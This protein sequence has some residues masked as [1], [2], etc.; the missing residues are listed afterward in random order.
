MRA[1]KTLPRQFEFYFPELDNSVL[2]ETCGDYVTIR[3]AR[4]NFPE[5]RKPFFVRELAAEGHIPDFYEAFTDGPM[6]GSEG[7]E[8][9]LD[10]SWLKIAPWW[11]RRAD[12]FM[13]RLLVCSV[14]C[15][16]IMMSR[17]I[18]SDIPVGRVQPTQTTIS[19]RV[20]PGWPF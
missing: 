8:W 1:N 12:R 4:D 18:S 15:W 17:L 3:A 10:R 16:L 14:V 20:P 19:N 7:I 13:R 6:D 9:V 11:R 2:V 5:Q